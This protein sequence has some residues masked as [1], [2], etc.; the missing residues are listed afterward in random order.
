[1]KIS[2]NTYRH[3]ELLG[4]LPS[5]AAPLRSLGNGSAVDFSSSATTAS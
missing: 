5:S 3:D 4:Y 2:L 1:M